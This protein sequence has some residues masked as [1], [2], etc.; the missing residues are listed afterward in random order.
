MTNFQYL[1]LEWASK[2][3]LTQRRGRAGRV[4]TGYCYRLVTRSFYESLDEYQTPEILRVS[5]DKL[6][7][8]IKKNEVCFNGKPKEVL[9]MAMQPPKLD[10]IETTIMKLKMV[11]FV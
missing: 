10:K 2:T 8:K 3:N 5:L 7:L 6:V 1:R 9:A 4:S 11:L